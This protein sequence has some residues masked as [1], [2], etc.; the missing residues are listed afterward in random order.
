VKKSPAALLAGLA[1]G[2][3][4]PQA[5][6]GDPRLEWYTLQ[7]PHFRVNFH[8]GLE[9]AAQRVAAVAE[10]AYG[11]L[12]KNLDQ[13]PSEVVEV[14][15]ADDSDFANGSAG[16]V[17]YDAIRLFATAPDDMSALSDYDDWLNELVTHEYTHILHVDN[18]SGLP[19]LLNKIMGKT[20]VPNHSQPRWILEGL[21]VAMETAHTTGGRLRSSQ[22][23]MYLRA[24]VLEHN[25]ARLDQMSGSPRRFPG[26][27]LWYLYG[28]GFVSFINDTYGPDVFAAVAD[29]YGAQVIPWGINRSIRRVTG[30]TYEELFQGWRTS[31]ELRFAEQVTKLRAHGL[32]EGKRLTWRGQNAGSARLTNACSTLGKPSVLYFRDDG[33]S[34]AGI[35]EVALDGS[36]P[37]GKLRARAGGV[38]LSLAPDCSIV[39][40]SSAVTERR[41]FF[42]DLFRQLPGTSSRE[43]GDTRERLTRG[44]R[45]RHADVSRDGRKVAF[46]TNERGTSTLRI[47]D[48]TPEYGLE[49]VRTLAASARYEQAFTPR[50]SPDG[51]S[52]AYSAWTSGGFR[53]IRIVDVASGRVREL[54]HDRAL[55]QQPT[56]SR[57]GRR[58]YF[59]SDRSGIA[60]VYAFD[61]KAGQLSQVTN[62]V[63]GAY[64]PELSEDES[65]LLYLGYTSQGWDLFVLENRPERWLP[66]PAY[67]DERGPST[68]AATT[69][70]YPVERYRAL[71]SL[72][73]HQYYVEYGPGAFGKQF[74]FTTSGSDIVGHHLI[75]AAIGIPIDVDHTDPNVALDYYYGRLPFGFQLSGFHSATPR[76]DYE[77]SERRPPIVEHLSGV[78]TGLSLGS[79]GDNESQYA[80]L[81]YTVAEFAQRLPLGLPDP[82]ASLPREPHRGLLGLLHFGYGYSNSESTGYAISRERGFDISVGADL[83]DRVLGS[84][85]SL[86]SFSATLTSYF[87]MPWLDHHV[88]ALALSGGTGSGTYPRRGLFSIGGFDDLPVIDAFTSNLRQSAF[89]LRGYE[90]AQFFGND[91]NLLNVEY[92]FPIWYADRGISTL[93][94]FLRTVSGTAFFDMG[95]AYD[96]LDLKDPL[97]SY[98][99]GV[100]AEL[101]LELLFGYYVSGN[102]RLGVARGLSDDAPGGWQTYTVVSSAF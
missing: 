89:R 91:F 97:A 3:L 59:T 52:V 73:P 2:L 79:P 8:S 81:S 72:R 13:R 102:L 27:N 48:L 20:A 57:D 15:L 36:E 101:W 74:L 56:F 9:P 86:V 7:T 90:A 62:V 31:L 99:Q 4:A 92:R 54:T 95:A 64:F 17:P 37:Q 16:A 18:V 67:V 19:A 6:A 44:L 42:Q 10:R 94:A 12:G 100:G 43:E 38:Q 71:P 69:R 98:H 24:D 93:P 30:R 55:D 83:A 11:I 40:D 5:L 25:F 68:V 41:Y 49:N 65:Q 78:T 82:Y 21:A 1:L 14:L 88:L 26:P 35:Y 47:A 46:V 60:N 80:S 23:E 77:Y 51:G 34:P 22:F 32:R 33:H 75:N 70:K 63:N 39:F 96:R 76:N 66:A 50:F 45:A 28:S 84:E 85:T 87:S 61:L 58:L 53:D 29:D